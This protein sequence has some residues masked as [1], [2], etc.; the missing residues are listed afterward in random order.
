MNACGFV[1]LSP[2][3][4]CDY[5]EHFLFKVKGLKYTSF[6]ETRGKALS[7]LD[8]PLK[9]RSFLGENNIFEWDDEIF[10]EA[11]NIGQVYGSMNK[12]RGRRENLIIEQGQ[13]MAQCHQHSL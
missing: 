12:K 8:T 11:K 3:L 6:K 4:V 2:F 10:K 9:A 7:G 13:E 1:H 5:K